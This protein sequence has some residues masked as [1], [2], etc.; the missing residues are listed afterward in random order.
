MLIDQRNGYIFAD[1]LDFAKKALILLE[2]TAEQTAL[3]QEAC[4]AR[5]RD[6][7]SETFYEKVHEV[8]QRAIRK[9]W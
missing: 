5:A 9:K 1:D 4:L 6:F 8:Y 7:S 2:R 3:M